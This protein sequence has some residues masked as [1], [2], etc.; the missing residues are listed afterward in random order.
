MHWRQYSGLLIFN[1]LV[2][3]QQLWAEFALFLDRSPIFQEV[4]LRIRYWENETIPRM[5]KENKSTLL[6]CLKTRRSEKKWI[7]AI[8]RLNRVLVDETK[9]PFICEKYWPDNFEVIKSRN[10]KIRP[11]NPSSIFK[12]FRRSELPTP[13]SPPRTEFLLKMIPV[14]I[15]KA[16]FLYEQV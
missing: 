9:K 5:P 15:M 13:P 6:D 16:K 1:W 10:G 12:G 4:G 2:M 8:P 14:Q 7:Q 3:W 11:K